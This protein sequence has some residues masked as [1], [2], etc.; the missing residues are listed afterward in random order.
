MNHVG[1]SFFLSFFLSWVACRLVVPGQRRDKQKRVS[2]VWWWQECFITRC[3]RHSRLTAL[4]RPFLT[5]RPQHNDKK[6]RNTHTRTRVALHNRTHTQSC[7][8]LSCVAFLGCQAL[9]RLEGR[10][11]GSANVTSTCIQFSLKICVRVCA[12]ACVCVYVRVCVS[13]SSPSR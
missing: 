7:A 5:R 13:T 1:L 9:G 2:S 11:E 8:A 3:C 6:Q 10:E 12:C 4:F